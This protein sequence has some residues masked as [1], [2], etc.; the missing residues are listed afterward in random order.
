MPPLYDWECKHCE[1]KVPLFKK[2]FDDYRTPP[3]D[4][5]AA[6]PCSVAAGH[7]WLKVMGTYRVVKSPGFGSKGNW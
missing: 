4:E 2:S 6:K 3:T 1:L 7:D 5:E